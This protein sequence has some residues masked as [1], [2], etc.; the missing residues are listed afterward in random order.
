MPCQFPAYLTDGLLFWRAAIL[1]LAE[2]TQP[3]VLPSLSVARTRHTSD[4]RKG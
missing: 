4:L 1:R 2:L 3:E